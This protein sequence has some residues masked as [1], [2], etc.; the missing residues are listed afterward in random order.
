MGSPGKLNTTSGKAN[1]S[2]NGSK[3]ADVSMVSSEFNYIAGHAKFNTAKRKMIEV[4]TRTC[5]VGKYETEKSEDSI[6]KRSPSPTIGRA[7]RGS[8]IDMVSRN[9][10]PGPGGLYPSLHFVSKKMK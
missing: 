2:M 9:D 5:S 6:L 8:W 4:N 10:S 1:T 7:A 3:L